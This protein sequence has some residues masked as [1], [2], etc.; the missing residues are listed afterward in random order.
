MLQLGEQMGDVKKDRWQAKSV[1]V[2]S[3]LPTQVWQRSPTTLSAASRRGQQQHMCI[4]CQD[5]YKQKDIL[6]T[7]PCAHMFHYGNVIVYIK[8]SILYTYIKIN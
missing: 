4:I 7:L 8:V 3:R 2:L 6:L 1:E 5:E